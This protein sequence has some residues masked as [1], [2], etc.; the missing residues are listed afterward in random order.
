MA[1]SEGSGEIRVIPVT[2]EEDLWNFQRLPWRI[3]QHDPY[4]V[5]PLLSHQRRFLDHRQGPF[6]AIGEARYFLARRR[7]EL[8]GRLSVHINGQYD[9]HNDA[10]TGFFGFF[11]CVPDREVARALFAAGAEWLRQRGKKRLLGPMNFTIYDEMGLLVEGY[12]SLPAIFQTHNPPYYQDLLTALGF[13][14]AMDWY[15]MRITNREIDTEAMEQRLEGMLRKP[16]IVLR[17]YAP[18]EFARRSEEAYELFNEAWASHWGHVPVSRQQF[19]S[20]LKE[21]K[22][23]LHPELVHMALAEDRLVGFSIAIPDLN[24]LVQKLRG[25][26]S[27]WGKL[28]LLYAAKYGKLRKVRGL[29]IA[30]RAAHRSQQLHTAM[31]L[32]T[33]VYLVRHTPCEFADFSLIPEYLPHWRRTLEILGAQRY[34]TFRIFAKEI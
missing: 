13:S 19:E 3:Y 20:F 16:S 18:Q 25:R 7:G 26:L 31:I 34:K 22:P 9:E 15:A 21:V 11:E 4:W 30:V 17:N 2:T 8:A 1:R 29:M 10:I 33:Y 6:F 14:K 24:P 27:L 5:P 23:L 32:R 28:R 12:D